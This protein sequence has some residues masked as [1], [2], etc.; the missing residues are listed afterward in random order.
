MTERGGD[1]KQLIAEP[2][3]LPKPWEDDM[4]LG[5]ELVEITL[6]LHLLPVVLFH[7]TLFHNLPLFHNLQ[8][9]LATSHA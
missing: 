3:I 6:P 5:I 1:L 7:L 9:D 4:P 2:P 8:R